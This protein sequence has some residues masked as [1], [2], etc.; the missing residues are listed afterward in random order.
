MANDKNKLVNDTEEEVSSR[1]E[2]PDN[3]DAEPE[4]LIKHP[5]QV[6]K[7]EFFETFKKCSWGTHGV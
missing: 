2:T 7:F 3:L 1:P 4:L 6:R 5:L